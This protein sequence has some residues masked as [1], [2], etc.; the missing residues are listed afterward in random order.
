M[1]TLTTVAID[2]SLQSGSRI[3]GS[4]LT[5]G[6]PRA[7]T[8]GLQVNS[9]T[10][11]RSSSP[12]TEILDSCVNWMGERIVPGDTVELQ[13]GDERAHD[14]SK[15]LSGDFLRVYKIHQ[16]WSAGVK[17]D[18]SL[19]GILFRRTKYMK[20]VFTRKTNDLCMLLGSHAA[21]EK[22]DLQYSM[23]ERP[24]DIAI[25][26]RELCLTN[27]DFPA[28]SFRTRA[29]AS[30]VSKHDK[31][32]EHVL[33]SRWAYAGEDFV[34]ADPHH[35]SERVFVRLTRGL[36]RT[37]LQPQDRFVS[38]YELRHT[39]HTIRS[40][41]EDIMEQ[42]MKQ[43]EIHE[44]SF[45]SSF[46]EGSTLDNAIDVDSLNADV[47]VVGGESDR[48]TPLEI[49]RSEMEGSDQLQQRNF[50]HANPH[51]KLARQK[52]SAQGD[53]TFCDAF[54]GAGAVSQAAKMAGLNVILAV[55][56]DGKCNVTYWNNHPDTELFMGPIDEFIEWYKRT[57]GKELPRIAILRIP[58]PCQFFSSMKRGPGKDDDANLAA[59]FS[60]QQ[61][62]EAIRPR[63]VTLEQTDGIAK[64]KEH[65]AYFHAL[66]GMFT[67][68]GYNLRSKVCRFADYE[69][70]QSRKRLIIF[71]T[72]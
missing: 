40:E 70:Y 59:L 20:G 69:S 16:N 49:S 62:V 66:L 23:V 72:W 37:V 7:V 25:K 52:R 55:D 24:L 68:N 31:F 35:L 6:M 33:V 46:E 12:I 2:A 26:K 61:L 47:V 60:V 22:G 30:G 54:H 48:E 67:A 9:S 57:F 34:L 39:R 10:R 51:S 14:A 17:G 21:A 53:Y 56:K 41:G 1:D 64:L 11:R 19:K 45:R 38:Q 15:L 32:H 27:E 18:I 13:Y 5:M 8:S 3:T 44:Q 50:R 4:T 28:H 63:V 58:P 65:R 29:E 43:A 71:A 42:F 36:C